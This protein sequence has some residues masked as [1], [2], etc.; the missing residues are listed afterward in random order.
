MSLSHLSLKLQTYISTNFSLFSNPFSEF[1]DACDTYEGPHDN[2]CYIA[3]WLEAGCLEHGYSYPSKL[4][5]S[6]LKTI[7]QMDIRYEQIL[8]FFFHIRSY[9][10][11][12]TGWIKAG[13]PKKPFLLWT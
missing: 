1:P 10:T 2:Q 3:L 8:I 6:G 12:L 4:T 7:R 11:A 5:L 13:P 9:K